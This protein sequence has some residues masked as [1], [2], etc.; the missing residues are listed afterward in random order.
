VGLNRARR[1]SAEHDHPDEH[2][3]LAGLR[4]GLGARRNRGPKGGA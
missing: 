1:P 4:E 2:T 3:G